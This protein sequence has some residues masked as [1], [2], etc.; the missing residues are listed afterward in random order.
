[1]TEQE[2]KQTIE[3]IAKQV[4]MEKLGQL[5]KL[6]TEI[7]LLAKVILDKDFTNNL[8]KYLETGDIKGISDNYKNTVVT[9]YAY[10][11]TFHY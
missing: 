11:R 3:P 4:I 9:I 6:K 8:L 1:M 2:Y 7:A 5:N 10:H